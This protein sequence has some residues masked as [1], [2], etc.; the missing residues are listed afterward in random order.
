MIDGHG[1]GYSTILLEM[2]S[3]PTPPPASVARDER[4]ACNDNAP[5]RSALGAGSAHEGD[6]L[7]AAR[8]IAEQ[9]EL[10]YIV[11]DCSSEKAISFAFIRKLNGLPA[12]DAQLEPKL[13]AVLAGMPQARHDD[14]RQCRRARSRRRG[15]ADRGGVPRP[16]LSRA[17][18]SP[19]SPAATSPTSCA[20]RIRSCAR[21]ASRSRRS[22]TN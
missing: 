12:Y 9:G 21:P 2:A 14:P 8:D 6:D 16:G 17:S 3:R 13:R 7:D 19:M 20:R 15:E 11:F 5:R 10:D 4:R 1:K 18:A 22:A